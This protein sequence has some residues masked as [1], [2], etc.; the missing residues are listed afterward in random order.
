MR[1]RRR[2]AAL[3]AGL[4]VFAAPALAATFN[5]GK[6]GGKTKQGK[7]ISFKADAQTSEIRSLRFSE[8]GKC[9]NG[10]QSRGSQGPLSADVSDTGKFHITG[11]STSGATKLTFNGTITGNKAHGSFTVKSR[12]NSAGK[13]DPN[14]SV[15]CSTGKVKWSAKKR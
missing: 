15:K 12:F 13:A 3:I 6:Y 7:K 1:G 9:N 2:L 11:T 10:D 8:R 4:L 14:G 5:G